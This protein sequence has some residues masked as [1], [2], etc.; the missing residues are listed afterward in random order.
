M[1]PYLFL[2]FSAFIAATLFPFSSEAVLAVLIAEG[3][4]K[5][6]LLFVATAGNTLGAMV[7]WLLGRFLLHFQSRSWFPVKSSSMQSAQQHFQRYGTWCLL[8][9]WLPVVGDALPFVAGIMRVRWW[10]VLV[11]CAVGKGARYAVIIYV[12]QTAAAL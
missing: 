9:S 8:F 5:S 12:V 2:F 3:K 1:T 7:N 6:L 4:D 11:L 10:L